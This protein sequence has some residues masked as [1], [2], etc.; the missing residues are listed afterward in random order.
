MRTLEKLAIASSIF[1]L[2][3]CNSGYERIENSKL[4]LY[5]GKKVEIEGIPLKFE[6]YGFVISSYGKEIFIEEEYTKRLFGRDDS[7]KACEELAQEIRDTNCSE[8]IKI[9]GTVLSSDV[10]SADSIEIHGVKYNLSP[11]HIDIF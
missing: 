1:A 9:Y 11:T 2:S 6:E 8:N 7:V 3:A 4:D 5:K 10:I